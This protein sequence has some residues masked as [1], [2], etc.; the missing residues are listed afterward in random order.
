MCLAGARA[1]ARCGL[2]PRP[3]RLLPWP[4][5]WLLVAE[6]R[7]LSWLSTCPSQAPTHAA[8]AA[9][10][11]MIIP[12]HIGGRMVKWLNTITVCPEESDNFY[13]FHDNRVLPP[14]VDQ[15]RAKNEG[16]LL[17]GSTGPARSSGVRGQ[18]ILPCAL[19]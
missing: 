11:R 9:Q 15:E 18:G 13:H 17:W 19:C 6:H 2:Q 16:A 7:L 10:V 12:G 3:L 14:N 5:S 4:S 1:A 8:P